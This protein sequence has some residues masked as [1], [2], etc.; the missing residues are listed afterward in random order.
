M[1]ACCS[2][3]RLHRFCFSLAI[4]AIGAGVLLTAGCGKSEY[5]ARMGQIK[6]VL[7]KRGS[8]GGSSD[9]FT[10]VDAASVPQGLKFPMPPTFKGKNV[11][12]IGEGNPQAKVPQVDIPGFCYTLE[13]QLDDDTGKKI[14]AYCYMYS[15]KKATHPTEQVRVAIR[16]GMAKH[17]SVATWAQQG[18]YT[19]IRAD[20]TFDFNVDGAVQKLPGTL[21]LY[22]F[23]TPENFVVIGWLYEKASGGKVALP[24]NI[25]T[26]MDLHRL[27]APPATAP[28]AAPGADP[29]GGPATAAPMPN[30]A[31]A[32]AAAPAAPGPGALPAAPGP[33]A[34][35]A[36]PGPAPGPVVP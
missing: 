19:A 18:G 22:G 24:A 2:R 31:A 32:P 28:A 20:A 5:E 25:A 23:E 29:A 36:A 11:T 34:L 12:S 26:A 4:A 3:H 10:V 30:A 1:P 7:S 27:D 8:G 21:I 6:S 16:Q 17:S 13:V 15:A 35:P 14:P 33:G 9:L